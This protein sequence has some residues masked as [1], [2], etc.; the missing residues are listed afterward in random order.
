MKR[1][2]SKFSRAKQVRP[3]I[4]PLP[5]S[6]TVRQT[7]AVLR[8]EVSTL[9]FVVVRLRRRVKALERRLERDYVPSVKFPITPSKPKKARYPVEFENA[10]LGD[11]G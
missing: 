1:I 11:E 5:K 3:A 9:L 10:E 8:D 4:F 6:L 7:V 2:K